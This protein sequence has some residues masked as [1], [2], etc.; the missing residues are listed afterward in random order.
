MEPRDS[1]VLRSGWAALAVALLLSVAA[2]GEEFWEQRPPAEWTQEQAQDFLND[3]PWGDKVS[4][5]QFSGRM[6]GTLPNGD[7][8]VVRDAPGAPPHHYSIGGYPVEPAGLEPE[9][10]RAVYGVVWSSAAIVRQTFER[11][12]ALSPA[13]ADVHAPPPEIPDTEY[14]ITVR[15]IQPPTEDYERLD[16]PL[17]V[18]SGG[19][20]VREQPASASDL[21]FGM[22][23]EELKA[24]AELRLPHHR[25]LEPEKAQRHGLGAGEGVTFFFPRQRNGQPTLTP[26][27]KHVEFVFKGKDGSELK[28]KFDLR[29]MHVG[30]RPDI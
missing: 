21:F 16:R 19:H 23:P 15:V 5:Y 22:T 26:E 2:L 20:P 10:L 28:A 8:V 29:K 1:R 25:T 12:R 4:V 24:G 11:L 3:S 7:K 17:L 6:L 13:V 30:G 9:R 14:A 27:D 18:N